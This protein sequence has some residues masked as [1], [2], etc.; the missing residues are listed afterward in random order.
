VISGAHVTVFAEDADAARAF[1]R[2]VLGFPCTDAGGGWLTFAI[3][4]TEVAFHPGAGWGRGEGHH[5]LFLMCEDIS[6]TVEELE[7]KGVEF[8]DPIVDEGFGPITRLRVPGAGAI[9]LY[10]PSY[11]SPLKE[12]S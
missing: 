11:P 8:L 9:G 2:D 7:G 1:F 4:P 10:Q 5:M 3:P 12:A 6:Q